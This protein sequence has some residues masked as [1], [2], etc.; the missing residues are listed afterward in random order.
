M[1]NIVTCTGIYQKGSI[2]IDKN[3]INEFEENEFV[4]VIVSKKNKKRSNNFN[5][6]YW[7]Y[8][9]PNV[10]NGLK[11]LGNKLSLS[12]TDIWL[13]D[14]LK[15]ITKEQTHEFLKERFIQLE[16]YNR[17]TGEINKIKSSSK[18]LSNDEFTEYIDEIIR[19]SIET[20]NIEL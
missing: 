14:F 3:C 4:D 1:K 12:E 2:I 15:T 7:S 5:A 10:R 8:I 17:Q 11:D 18:Q 9:I 20:L 19:F 13:K 6:Y 16:T